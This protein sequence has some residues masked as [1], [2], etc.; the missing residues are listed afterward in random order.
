LTNSP[1]RRPS[2]S[3]TPNAK[4]AMQKAG[5][6]E[7]ER[8]RLTIMCAPGPVLCR[9]QVWASVP[10]ILNMLIPPKHTEFKERN[11]LLL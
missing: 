1:R 11:S 5:K 8:A 4:N 10:K 9:E 2:V 6:R 3:T 7:Q